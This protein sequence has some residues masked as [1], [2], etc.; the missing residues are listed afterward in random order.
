MYEEY[1]RSVVQLMKIDVTKHGIEPSLKIAGEE[2][3]PI[4][5]QRMLF[6]NKQPMKNIQPRQNVEK[7]D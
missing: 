6:Q 1:K 5:G 2:N 4:S 3:V 7:I